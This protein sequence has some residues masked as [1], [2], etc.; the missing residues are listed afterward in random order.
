M[1]NLRVPSFILP[2]LLITLSSLS[3]NAN[4]VGARQLLDTPL[5]EVPKPKLP[6]LPP[7]PKVDLPPKP[8][9]PELPKPDLAKI[10]ELPKPELPKPELP[11][12][13]HLPDLP[14]PTLPTIPN[15]PKDF[16]VIPTHSVTNP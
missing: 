11:A 12:F 7:L 8:E 5:P 14:K 2:I 15:L 4:L 13:P 1:A 16:P 9:L 6:E 10:P 3:Y